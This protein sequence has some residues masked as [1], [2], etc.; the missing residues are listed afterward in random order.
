MPTTDLTTQKLL[1]A[2]IDFCTTYAT[3]ALAD[4]MHVLAGF[5]NRITLPADGND[6]CI[7]TPISQTRSGTT[8]ERYERDGPDTQELREYVD[9]DVQIDCYSTNLFDARQRAATLETV[10]R[11]S[12]GVAHF[13]K[14]DI[15][16]LYSDTVQNLSAVIDSGQYVSRWMLLLHLG[17]WKRVEVAQDFFSAVDVRLKNVDVHF[18]P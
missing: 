9:L 1:S 15:D 14:Y 3:P 8:I 11:S 17:Y 13:L 2:L 7:V 10:A 6:I 5:G 18:K 12:V 4:D 16:C